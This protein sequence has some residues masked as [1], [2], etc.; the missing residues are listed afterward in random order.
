[1]IHRDEPRSILVGLVP[2]QK[3]TIGVRPRYWPRVNKKMQ[4]VPTERGDAVE[5]IRAVL[6]YYG[7]KRRELA[8][9]MDHVQAL[10]VGGPDS[11]EN[12]WAFDSSANMSAGPRQRDQIVTYLDKTSGLAKQA[13]TNELPGRWFVIKN[14]E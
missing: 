5:Q 6:D 12:V 11:T 4:Y 1:T 7:L 2:G 3:I 10:Q 8:I 9:Q 13:K 14:I